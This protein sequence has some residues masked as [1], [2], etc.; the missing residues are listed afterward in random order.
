MQYH[1]NANKVEED[2]QNGTDRIAVIFRSK[3]N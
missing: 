2:S 3:R 1:F